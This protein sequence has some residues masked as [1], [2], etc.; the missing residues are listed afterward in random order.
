MYEQP[1]YRTRTRDEPDFIGVNSNSHVLN[2]A[3]PVSGEIKDLHRSV[4]PPSGTLPPSWYSVSSLCFERDHRTDEIPTDSI[5]SPKRP[6]DLFGGRISRACDAGA[7]S[8][9]GSF[10][11]L[12]VGQLEGG[13]IIHHDAEPEICVTAGYEEWLSLCSGKKRECPLDHPLK[14]S[15]HRA[16][17]GF[18]HCGI[19]L[20]V[21]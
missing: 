1:R 5:H 8:S 17:L 9:T 10:A 18:F 19:S 20:R 6:Y 16:H 14:T 21:T 7:G 11:V 2:V 12:V 15:C 4:K 3:P 13:E